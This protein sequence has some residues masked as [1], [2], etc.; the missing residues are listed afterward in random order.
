VIVAD[1]S[2]W[3]EY[4]RATGSNVDLRL[5]EIIDAENRSGSWPLLAVTDP[6][7]AE[8]TMGARTD[9]QEL[10]L[11]RMLARFQFLPFDAT[12]D[13]DGAVRIYRTCRQEGITPRGLVGCMIAAVAMRHG[14]ALLAQ[15][16]DIRRIA[17]VMDLRLDSY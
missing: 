6:V 11:R 10:A 2:A 9:K 17:E 14:A 8:V 7:I 1:T 15:D 12:R 13:F 5:T 16:A 4:D 3:I